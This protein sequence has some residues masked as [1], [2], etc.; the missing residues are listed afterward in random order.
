MHWNKPFSSAK[1]HAKQP[2]QG[3]CREIQG[4]SLKLLKTRYT[5]AFFAGYADADHEEKRRLKNSFSD[6]K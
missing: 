6:T 3:G 4:I 5:I 1:P 2:P